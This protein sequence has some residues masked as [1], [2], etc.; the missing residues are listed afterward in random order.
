MAYNDVLLDIGE[1]SRFNGDFD[2]GR[3]K[4][5]GVCWIYKGRNKF[6]GAK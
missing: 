4:I 6:G 1:V 5:T 2:I 3:G